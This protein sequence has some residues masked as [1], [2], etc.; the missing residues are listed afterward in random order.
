MTKQ[1]AGLMEIMAGQASEEEELKVTM[2]LENMNPSLI[3][4]RMLSLQGAN[5]GC[6]EMVRVRHA[7]EIVG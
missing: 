3:P 1:V 2:L 5:E 4:T 7:Y 6:I